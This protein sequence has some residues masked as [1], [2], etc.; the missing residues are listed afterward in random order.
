[1][2]SPGPAV[3][4]T[5]RLRRIYIKSFREKKTSEDPDPTGPT[6]P[7]RVGRGLW[8]SDINLLGLDPPDPPDPEYK[9]WPPEPLRGPFLQRRLDP[10]CVGGSGA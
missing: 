2:V 7:G 9:I 1:M 8:G 6:G 5:R 10:L 4:G 3:P